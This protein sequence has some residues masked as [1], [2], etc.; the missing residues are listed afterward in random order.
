MIFRKRFGD[1]IERQ[2]D[3]FAED[4]AELLEQIEEAEQAYDDAARDEAEERFGE[5]SDLVL[6]G[7]EALAD[8]RDSYAQTLD[9]AAAEE[10]EAAFNFAV[11]RRFPPFAL[12]IEE[13]EP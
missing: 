12:E 9:E 11:L 6:Q 10:Y 1:L 7:T 8:I 5:Y 3:L 4:N 2:L 13:E